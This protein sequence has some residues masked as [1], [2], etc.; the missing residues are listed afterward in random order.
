VERA[1]DRDQAQHDAVAERL[2]T[3]GHLDLVPAR[4]MGPRRLTRRRQ[5]QPAV[6]AQAAV[7]AEAA[8]IARE[9]GVLRPELGRVEAD[10]LVPLEP[11]DEQLVVEALAEPPR[12]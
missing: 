2:P 5:R 12:L 4:R 3:R 7:P 9:D 6:A 1:I 8:G 11:A 10:E